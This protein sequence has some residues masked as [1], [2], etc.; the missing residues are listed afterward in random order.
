MINYFDPG[1]PRLRLYTLEVADDPQYPQWC[2]VVVNVVA[3]DVRAA[4]A[5]LG[6]GPQEY[7]SKVELIME[8][9][10]I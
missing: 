4:I 9:D 5:K 1:K 2:P 7:V 10:V 8:V 6:L 3:H